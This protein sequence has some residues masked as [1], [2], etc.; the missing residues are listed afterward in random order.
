MHVLRDALAPA[1]LATTSDNKYAPQYYST[2]LP[3][4]RRILNSHSV[5]IIGVVELFFRN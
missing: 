1:R 2:D 3:V 5:P 4:N